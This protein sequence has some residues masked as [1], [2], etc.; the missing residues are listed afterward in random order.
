MSMSGET[1]KRTARELINFPNNLSIDWKQIGKK[2]LYVS[3]CL[4]NRFFLIKS[5]ETV[6]GIVDDQ[7]ADFFEIGKYSPTTSKQMTFIYRDRF[8]DCERKFV[9]GRV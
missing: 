6:V 8:S 9:E 5:Y 7:E 1:A 4:R 2:N 3:Q